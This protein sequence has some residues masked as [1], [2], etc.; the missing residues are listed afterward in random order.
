MGCNINNLIRIP[1]SSPSLFNVFCQACQSCLIIDKSNVQGESA[2]QKSNIQ[3]LKSPLRAPA[4]AQSGRQ[5]AVPIRTI[6][7]VGHRLLLTLVQSVN[8]INL[9]KE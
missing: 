9:K 5:F 7:K 2:H 3:Y 1:Q 6:C 8:S 4:R